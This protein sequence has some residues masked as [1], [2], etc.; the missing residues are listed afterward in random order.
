M[1][2]AGTVA[3]G[4]VRWAG[5]AAVL[6]GVLWIPYGV[7]EMLQPWGV[8]TDYRDDLGY[9]VI[10]N[11]AL[12]RTYSLPGGLASLLTSLGLLGAFALLKLPVGRSGRIG[13][14]FAYLAVVLSAL[15]V[16]GVIVMFD[17]LFTAPRIFGS[18]ALGIATL[19]AGLDARKTGDGAGWT[20][21]LLILGLAGMFLLPLWPLVYAI[22][23][24]SEAAGA[25]FIALFGLGWLATGYRLWSSTG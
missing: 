2:F 13:L 1:R 8:D 21:A 5:L 14:L 18:L 4:W 6:G 20:I 22:Q 11:A 24:L 15:S 25:T 16:V 7:F 17:P 12:Y 9:E 10:T 23:V 3:P 19:L